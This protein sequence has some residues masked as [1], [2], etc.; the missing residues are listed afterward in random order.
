MSPGG[1]SLVVRLAA[2]L[3]GVGL[4]L[5]AVLVFV[6]APSTERLF[7]DAS[8]RLIGDSEQALWEQARS[9]TDR[10]AELLVN[11][12]RETTDARGRLLRD[13]PLDLYGGDVERIRERILEQD[14]ARS[15]QVEENVIVLAGEIERRNAARIE[16]TLEALRA[17]QAGL[18]EGF[19]S[20]LGTDVLWIAGGVLL[21]TLVAL[22][23][24]LFRSVI[25]PVRALQRVTQEVTATAAAGGSLDVAMPRVQGAGEVTALASDFGA[26][27]EQL[28]SSRAQLESLNQALE[29]EVERKSRQLVHAEKMASIGTLAGGVAHEFN[30]V[31]GGVHGCLREAIEDAGDD[32]ERREP[33]EIAKRATERAGGIVRQLLDFARPPVGRKETVDLARLTEEAVGL[34]SPQARRAS[35]E[36]ELAGLVGAAPGAFVVEADPGALH[37]VLLNLLTNAVHAMPEGGSVT[38]RLA[39]VQ[40]SIGG[41]T[42]VELAVTDTGVGIAADA[43]DHVFDPFFTSKDAE[44]DAERRGSGL[45]LS[46]SY[47][48]VQAHGGALSVES[49]VGAGSTFRMRLPIGEGEARGPSPGGSD[50]GGEGRG[51]GATGGGAKAGGSSD[52]GAADDGDRT[53]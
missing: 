35:V 49:L 11:L 22:G 50:R 27:L 43:I 5:A 51:L 39:R 15:H 47:G 20:R 6:F 28:R 4:A 33:L 1:P 32:V 8:T 25:V 36:I 13:L 38:C 46:V 44:A 40:P 34:V 18:A 14:A 26:M 19:G 37:Q 31:I 12:I 10:T 23:F 29:D 3:V 45:G 30:N 53:P 17:R 41:S 52:D 2:V 48:I 24:G 21:A 16:R 7:G 9:D 42:H